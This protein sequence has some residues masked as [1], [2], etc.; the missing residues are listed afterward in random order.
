MTAD[1][2]IPS[3]LSHQF[4]TLYDSFV[5]LQR[6]YGPENA[7]LYD[8]SLHKDEFEAL[9]IV[10]ARYAREYKKINSD[11]IVCSWGFYEKV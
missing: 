6:T 9:K 10:C 8:L 2:S 5:E 7:L 11:L 4:E 3:E 1:N